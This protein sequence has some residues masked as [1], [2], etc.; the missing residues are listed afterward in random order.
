MVRAV[1][2]DG[3]YRISGRWHFASGCANADWLNVAAPIFDGPAPRMGP[4]GVPQ[5]VMAFLEPSTVEIVDTW[6][7]T[8]LRGSG[9]HDLNADN[10]FVPTEMTGGFSMAGA[11]SVRDCPLAR[12]PFMTLLAMV[13]APPVCLGI[14][15]HVIEEFAS[16]AASK[17][18]PPAPKLS[19]QV[20]A[21]VGIARA[22]APVESASAYD[23]Q[24]VQDV[25]DKTL[26]E[27]TLTLSDRA[28]VRMACITAAENTVAAVDLLQRLSGSTAVFQ[29]NVIERCWRD[30]HT[31]A[32]HAQV[33][34]ARWENTGR[35]LLG[36]EPNDFIV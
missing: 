18:R 15:R 30:I 7:C 11:E 8:G 21:Q 23:Y 17:E 35:I 19:E 25:W 31:A 12:M 34:D 3:G 2:V 14:A 4:Y 5:M 29:A 6:H 27:E 24:T 9:S 16:L 1:A 13:Q 22:T 33:Q 28:A 36:L 26:R 32:Q 10:L 20:P